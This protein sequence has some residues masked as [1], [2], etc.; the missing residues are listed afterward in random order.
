MKKNT[1]DNPFEGA[2]SDNEENSELDAKQDASQP[3]DGFVDA[4][5]GAREE[6]SSGKESRSWSFFDTDLVSIFVAFE[7]MPDVVEDI[8]GV[9]TPGTDG[10]TR[11]KMVKA[12]LRRGLDDIDESLFEATK[13]AKKREIDREW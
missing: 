3:P 11:S 1:A 13:E 4:V 2:L 10:Y 12:L 6:I 8:D 7:Q 9:P 5:L